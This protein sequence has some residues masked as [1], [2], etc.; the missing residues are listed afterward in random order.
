V[1]ATAFCGTSITSQSWAQARNLALLPDN[2]HVHFASSDRRGYV[3]VE[4]SPRLCQ[5]AL[6]GIENEERRATPIATQATFVV[7]DGHPG[8]QT[9]CRLRAKSRLRRSGR[10]A[11]S[12]DRAAQLVG[13]LV[14][15]GFGDDVGWRD[16]DVIALH[17][18]DRPAHRIAQE[19]LLQALGL[20]PRMDTQRGIE[21][22]PGRAVLHELDAPEKA[23]AADVAHVRVLLQAIAQARFQRR[24]QRAHALDQA[25]LDESALHG[26]SGGAR[27]R[28][29]DVGMAVL[30]EARARPDRIVDA[31]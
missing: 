8:A 3:V 24:R 6:R 14:E 27:D 21:R 15:L 4:L 31:A 20:H 13:E 9:A 7:E 25:A 22:A 23:A 18:V 12:L 2:P 1:V 16:Q 28:V 19:A 5:V 10:V 26:E 29:A 11:G 30:E 17:A